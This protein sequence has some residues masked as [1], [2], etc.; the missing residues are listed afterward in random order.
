MNPESDSDVLNQLAALERI[1]LEIICGGNARFE[2]HF[3]NRKPLVFEGPTDT[4]EE[5][6]KKVYK[7]FAEEIERIKRF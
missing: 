3:S 4:M 1:N 6:L 7:M 5:P 2:A